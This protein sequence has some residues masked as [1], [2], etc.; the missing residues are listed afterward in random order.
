MSG[1]DYR[2]GE[3]KCVVS[4]MARREIHGHANLLPLGAKGVIQHLRGH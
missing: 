4:L 1:S 3:S 2:S